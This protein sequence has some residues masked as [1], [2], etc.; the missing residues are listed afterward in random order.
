M[1]MAARIL[2]DPIY[3][4]SAWMDRFRSDDLDEVR[5]VIAR[6]DGEH[7][8]VAHGSGPLGFD[9]S[10]LS[11]EVVMAGWAR[12][13]LPLTIRGALPRP[14][15]HLWAPIGSRYRIGRREYV[16]GPR[17]IMFL[18]EGQEFSRRSPS[19][20]IMAVS[21]D[22]GRLLEEVAARGAGGHGRSMLA[23]QRLILG[24][25]ARARLAAH[26]RD[27]MEGSAPGADRRV[28]QRS[29]ARLL[30]A[31]ADVLINGSAVVPTREATSAR[32]ARL[33]A[34]IEANLDRPLTA[35]QLCRIAGVSQRG[36]EKTF[37]LRRGM[38]PMRFVAERRLAAAHRRLA[39]AGP[40]D[41]V[42]SIATA[43][44]ISHMGRFAASY[45]QAFGET[46]SESLKRAARRRN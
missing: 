29:E 35:G 22:A 21:V 33:E 44:G 12:A 15:L 3:T 32:L 18:A 40:E 43:V 30:S 42:T 28:A 7:S 6:M 45:R 46:P 24:R 26:V 25:V 2:H 4:P 34:W 13:S 20:M 39:R 23:T 37:E 36:L 16:G 14:V 41:D 31:V 38:S 27:L 8:R 9:M 19:G 10:R 17:D 5:E 11:G 1:A